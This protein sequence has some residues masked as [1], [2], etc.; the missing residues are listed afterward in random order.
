MPI[1]YTTFEPERALEVDDREA[2]YLRNANLLMDKGK[3]KARTEEPS[4]QAKDEDSG[5]K[6][7]S[8]K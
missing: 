1:V 8:G 4:P 2:E 6:A 7:R 5:A 3:A